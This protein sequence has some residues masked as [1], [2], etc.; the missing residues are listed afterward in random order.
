MEA[1]HE[2]TR[3]AV[4][5]APVYLTKFHGLTADKDVFGNRQIGTEVHLLVHRGNPQLNRILGTLRLNLPAIQD[6]RSAILVMNTRQAFNQRGF[7]GAVFT[8][9]G[10]NLAGSQTEIHFI[11]CLYTR[12]LDFDLPHFKNIIVWQR[13]PSSFISILL[14]AIRHSARNRPIIRIQGG[15]MSALSAG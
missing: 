11:Q 2:F 1:P 6:N 15:H 13:D 5:G 10:M 3:P 12:K 4:N 14:P 8:Q 7:P 9:Q